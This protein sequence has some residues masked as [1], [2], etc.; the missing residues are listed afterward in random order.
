MDE[1]I[2]GVG[3]VAA[4]GTVSGKC[5]IC[6]GNYLDDF[7]KLPCGHMFCL[8][9][10]IQWWRMH[11]TCPFCRE[12]IIFITKINGEMIDFSSLPPI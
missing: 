10:V 12:E 5:V 1:M 4:D 11:N 2:L 3:V 8:D 7:G 6:L 9:C